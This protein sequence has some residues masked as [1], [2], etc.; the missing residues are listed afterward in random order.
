MKRYLDATNP[1]EEEVKY[2]GTIKK[3]AKGGIDSTTAD[4]PGQSQWSGST[5]AT[6]QRAGSTKRKCSRNRRPTGQCKTGGSGNKLGGNNGGGKNG[7]SSGGSKKQWPGNKRTRHRRSPHDFGW[8]QGP[9]AKFD[10]TPNTAVLKKTIGEVQP[11]WSQKA[12]QTND[13][14]KNLASIFAG[15]YKTTS[16]AKPPAPRKPTTKLTEVRL[17]LED[18]AEATSIIY[19]FLCPI[20]KAIDENLGKL[21][22]YTK[23]E[24]VDKPT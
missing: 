20:A 16:T 14:K 21:H 17:S 3:N 2:L 4:K 24:P 11:M 5:S 6:S 7:G 13:I 9:G 8:R 15:D 10:A 23:V 12:Q 18:V 19:C 22:L 1:E